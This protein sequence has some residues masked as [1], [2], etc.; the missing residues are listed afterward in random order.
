MLSP[1]DREVL[2]LG[3]G[4]FYG[5]SF[6][7]VSILP[8]PS[9]SGSPG[10]MP[11]LPPQVLSDSPFHPTV[12]NGPHVMPGLVKRIGG[13][14]GQRVGFTLPSG[15]HSPMGRYRAISK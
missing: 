8:F 15:A 9:P 12:C 4:F 1:P 11:V 3:V 5:H 14:P 10:P 2:V 13:R 6:Q 7:T